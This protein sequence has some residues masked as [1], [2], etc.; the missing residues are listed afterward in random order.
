[1]AFSTRMAVAVHAIGYLAFQE[2]RACT[3]EEIAWSVDTHPVAIRRLLARLREAEIVASQAGPGGGWHLARPVDQITLGDVFRAVESDPLFAL[4][5]H[6]ARDDCRVGTRVGEVLRS[7]FAGAETALLKHLDC[8]TMVDVIVDV[9]VLMGPSP[10]DLPC[11]RFAQ[12]VADASALTPSD[13]HDWPPDRDEAMSS[14]R[15]EPTGA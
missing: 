10:V 15:T 7:R 1:M 2:D 5:V 13:R 14:V 11:G 4:P 3:S 9:A 6:A 12:I 8:Q